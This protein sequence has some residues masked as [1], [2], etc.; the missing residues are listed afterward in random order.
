MTNF[1]QLL[2]GGVLTGCI[3]ALV[4]LGF[5]LIFRVTGVVNLAQGAFCILAALACASFEMQLGWSIP[6]SCIGA[7]VVA[8][9]VGAVV[10]ATSFVP[11]LTRLSNA[12]MLMLTAG[13]LTVFEGAMQLIWGSQP[14]TL[15]PFSGQEPLA[16]AGIT[17]P[18][19]G[20]WM[21]GITGVLVLALWALL[22][23]T[24]LGQALR[25]CS[26]NPT[27]ARLMG[28]SVPRMT[29]FS[30][31]LSA[32]I[33]AIAGVVI[34]P[35]TSLQFDSG[36][37][38]TVSG[39][40]AA[41]IGGIASLPGAIVGGLVLGIVN[42]LATAYLSS[43]YSNAIALGL[44]LV[45]LVWRP[46]GLMAGGPA[47]RQDVRDEARV[48]K[49][50][51]RLSPAAGRFAAVAALVGAIA[52]PH[53]VP[54]E[55]ILSS[56]VIVGILFVALI[57]LDLLMG[58]CGQVALGQ[59]GFMAIGGYTAAGLA[60]EYQVPPLL[61]IL[62]GMG[63]SLVCALILSVVTLRLRGLYLALAT[64]SFGLLV[65]SFA[66][67]LTELTGGPSGMVGIPSLEIGGYAFD[68]TSSMYHLVL[69]L[70]VVLVVISQGVMRS[71]FGRAIQAI[72]TDQMAAAAL[73]VNV[74]QTKLVVFAVS[75][76]LASLS[77]S[78]YAFNF[79]FL[80]PDMVDATRSLELVAMLVIGGEGT[81][82]GPLIGGLLLTLLPTV[83]APLA[84]AKTLVSGLLL[85]G[86]FLWLPHGLY[87]LLVDG[88]NGIFRRF[89]ETARPDAVREEGAR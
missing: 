45:V 89:G 15:E 43:L 84:S 85:V 51:H 34:A 79:H 39:F 83:F 18:T 61:G 58:W 63:L 41:V 57:G 75:A 19:Q 20:L 32:L 49:R 82:I 14:Y 42:S 71:S 47:R 23:R 1:I 81:L 86:C 9:A 30:F 4:A 69:V 37:L 73:G 24:R 67:G 72:R 66:V 59:A 74:L 28:V 40:I 55:A 77:G 76:M 87:G 56:L 2:I 26:E 6:A 10:G 25:A 70:D 54:S 3:Y 35:A 12:N 88:L 21:L 50:V 31:C 5:S 8:V 65:T 36:R 68:T 7:V 33:A 46:S 64:L 60:I 78:L 53:A 62:A 48:W 80:S 13:L 11:G 22:T 52:L 27:A 38:F 17:I 44:L 16:F 29:L